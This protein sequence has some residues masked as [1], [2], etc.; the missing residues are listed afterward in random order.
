MVN[1]EE[2]VTQYRSHQKLMGYRALHKVEEDRQ[3]YNISVPSD[4]WAKLKSKAY[5]YLV[6]LQDQAIP[7]VVRDCL[8]D[9]L[10]D[11][12]QGSG[13]IS[14]HSS[15]LKQCQPKNLI[16]YSEVYT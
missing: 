13:F 16:K 3:Q 10:F 11:P 14:I 4:Q 8:R 6:I 15:S 5:A 7:D 9:R 12:F 2:R 1:R